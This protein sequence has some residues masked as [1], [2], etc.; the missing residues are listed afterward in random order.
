MT[1]A[2]W[3]YHRLF[4]HP[5][6]VEHLVRDFVPA[7]SAATLDFARMERVSAKFLGTASGTRRHG[8]IVWRLPTRGG[9]DIYLYLLLEFQSTQ[10]WWMAV[11]TQVYEG[12]L[13]Q[14]IIAEH[15][16]K[17][18]DRLPPVLMVVLYNGAAPWKAPTETAPLIALPQGSELWPW[19]PH[20]R[21]HLLDMGR[22]PSH[23]LVGGET[24]AA[25]LVR[26]ERR[27][28]PEDLVQVVGAVVDWFRAHPDYA[29]LRRLFSELVTQ[30]MAGVGAPVR[31]PDDLKEVQTMLATLGEEWKRQWKAEGL[32]EGRAQGR[33]EGRAQGR[34]AALVRLA[35]HRFGA[36]PEADR[37]TISSADEVTLNRWLD[38]VLDAD[39][40]SDLLYGNS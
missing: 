35:E 3:I 18:G 23:R 20:I 32:A 39:S 34:A 29:D 26:L 9:S 36:V 27:Q 21:Y 37:E 1:D 6:M 8:D 2:D 14:H 4:S 17:P 31:W 7:V 33:A 40:L 22:V 28:Q 13:W 30:A 15:R 19:Q 24:L 5:I 38:R 10:D 12:L 16:L 11:R 25:L